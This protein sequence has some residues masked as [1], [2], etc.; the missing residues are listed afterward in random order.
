MCE[1]RVVEL[2]PTR[3]QLDDGS[4]IIGQSGGGSHGEERAI[5]QANAAGKHIVGGVAVGVDRKFETG[6]DHIAKVCN[7]CEKRL[8]AHGDANNLVVSVPNEVQRQ[9]LN[10]RF[11]KPQNLPKTFADVGQGSDSDES[12]R[13]NVGESSGHAANTVK[14]ESRKA[15]RD[16]S[17][18]FVNAF[19]YSSEG[20]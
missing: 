9:R 15:A 18:K 12:F 1:W 6:V 8:K 13:G 11:G 20:E 7:D 5:A 2:T 14:S 16:A 4:R 17:F 19:K 3:K 10:N